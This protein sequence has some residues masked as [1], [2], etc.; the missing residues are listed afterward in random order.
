MSQVRDC[1]VGRAMQM[2][3]GFP[4][5][6]AMSVMTD[7]NDRYFVKVFGTISPLRVEHDVEEHFDT[8]VL[9]LEDMA[10]KV[11]RVMEANVSAD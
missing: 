2:I 7:I 6:Y 11:R 1:R 5:F 4:G 9:A 8:L 10:D 3:T